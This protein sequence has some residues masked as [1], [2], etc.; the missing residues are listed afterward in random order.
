MREA[1]RSEGEVE[2]QITSRLSSLL[3]DVGRTE[4]L[5]R[6][7]RGR[8]I[9]RRSFR[10]RIFRR[11]TFRS[12][13]FSPYGFFAI[14]IFA[15]RYFHCTEFLPYGIFAVWNFRRTEFSPCGFFAVILRLKCFMVYS[16]FAKIKLSSAKQFHSSIVQL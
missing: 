6:T 1:G 9:R 12:T 4:G 8:N 16:S 15:V 13:D 10:R 3:T 5:V 2:Q 7:R 11:R 14:G